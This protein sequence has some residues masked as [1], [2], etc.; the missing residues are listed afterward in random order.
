MPQLLVHC[1]RI[2]PRG[3]G[4]RMRLKGFM[5]VPNDNG[6]P[7]VGRGEFDSLVR[8]VSSLERGV[9]LLSSPP[10]T[11]QATT[12]YGWGDQAGEPY[13]HNQGDIAGSLRGFVPWIGATT[14][15]TERLTSSEF[16]WVTV[17][18]SITLGV[19]FAG[20]GTGA[21]WALDFP[22]AITGATAGVAGFILSA[23]FLIALKRWDIHTLAKGQAN[24]DKKRRTEM[25]VQID[26]PGTHGIDFLYLNSN[27]TEDQLRSFA[28]RALRGSSLAVHKWVGQGALFTRGQYDDLMTELEQM[29]YV[30]KARGPV[31][32]SLTAKGRALM[33]GLAE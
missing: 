20:L 33:R 12:S 23:A 15:F 10:F 7:A 22:I 26:K 3:D 24:K 13:Y 14:R 31:A 8:R 32:R 4:E 28:K 5:E 11:D 17:K 19:C 29:N 2:A 16:A 25:R 6:V 30:T 18:D 27:I 1:S 9:K 21:A